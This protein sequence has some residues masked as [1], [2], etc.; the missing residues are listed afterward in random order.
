LCEEKKRID[1]VEDSNS[2]EMHETGVTKKTEE[3]VGEN[4]ECSDEVPV[5]KLHLSSELHLEVGD[6]PLELR[7]CTV[8]AH[9]DLLRD[10]CTK[11]R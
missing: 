2:R 11:R 6:V 7:H 10:L 1:I 5:S 4:E 8:V 9:P 3:N